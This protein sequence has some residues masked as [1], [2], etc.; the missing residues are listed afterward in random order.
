MTNLYALLGITYTASTEEI[1]R[2][3]AR[4]NLHKTL[5]PPVLDKCR[6][7]LLNP[8]IRSKYNGKL[9]HECPELATISKQ[10]EVAHSATPQNTSAPIQKSVDFVD[11][12]DEIATNRPASATDFLILIAVIAVIVVIVKAIF[13]GSS[14]TP[15]KEI[16]GGNYPYVCAEKAKIRV[17]FPAT[18]EY[19][20]SRRIVVTSE[21]G[22]YY[23]IAVPITAQNAFGVPQEHTAVC[24]IDYKSGTG[25]LVTVF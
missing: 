22:D 6:Q 19:D 11:D 25:E 20:A 8:V 5:P 12:G 2:A 18:L 21:G 14:T 16:A 17:N 1:S 7:I 13:G 10:K 15:E 24:K 3:I 9:L 23:S 4:A